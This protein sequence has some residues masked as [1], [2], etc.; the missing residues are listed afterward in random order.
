MVDSSPPLVIFNDIFTNS[1]LAA[2][3]L[4]PVVHVKSKLLVVVT[5]ELYS[6]PTF[7]VKFGKVAT[8]SIYLHLFQG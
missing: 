1:G 8:Y 4:F 3:G 5:H 6:A 2:G 7:T